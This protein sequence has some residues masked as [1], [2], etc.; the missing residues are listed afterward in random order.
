MKT[1]KSFTSEEIAAL[2]P[3]EKIALVA[4]I[5]N[6]GLPHVTLLTSLLALDGTH[7][8]LGEFSKGV[9]KEYFKKNNNIGF[10]ILTMK[11][12]M[13]RG[14]ARYTHSAQEGPEYEM[15][16]EF[17]MFRYNT[18]FGINTVHYFDLI[19]ANEKERLP[20]GAIAKAY[21]ATLFAKWAAKQKKAEK[22]LGTVGFEL[23]NRMDALKFAA[24]IDGDGFPKLVP[25]LQAKAS[26]PGT[27]VFS[28]QAYGKELL[29]IKEG[30]PVA[31]YALTVK[32][33]NILTR[34]IFKGYH[35]YAG[36]KLGMCDVN[37]VYNSMPPVHGQIY[38]QVPL[39]PVR[40]F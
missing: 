15:L 24:W 27:I 3:N 13:W 33:E 2:K 10:L 22:P 31:F 17:P 20:F 38:P 34:G 5:N 8:A 40:D 16:N 6:E 36:I 30:T 25:V 21:V 9:S 4:T 18:Y 23:F 35:R 32:M 19:E 14:K 7:M 37:W 39:E 26:D 1:R 11:M 12:D 28:P 29:Q